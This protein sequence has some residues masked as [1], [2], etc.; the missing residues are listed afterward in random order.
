MNFPIPTLAFSS[1]TLILSGLSERAV[2]RIFDAE[3][4]VADERAGYW[5]CDASRYPQVRA[6]L[7]KLIGTVDDRVPQW[8]PVNWPKTVLHPLRA[9][10]EQAVAAWFQNSGRGVVLMPTGTGKTEVAL[11]ILARTRTSTLVIAPVRDLMYQWHRRLL[12]K[13]GV[14]AGIIGDSVYRVSPVSVT[15]YDSACIHMPRFGNQFDVLVFDE[16]H[17]LPGPVRRDAALMSA[18]RYRLGLTATLERSDGAHRDLGDLIGPLAYELTVPAARGKSLADYNVIRI[19]VH[20]TESERIR[21]ESL[22]RQ[23]TSFVQ[24]RRREDPHFRW[25]D[26]CAQAN[27]DP[28]AR[29]ALRAFHTKKSMED[30]AEEKLRVLED[31]F[32][33][34]AG[35]PV[36]VFTGSNA[37]ARDVS[38]RFLIPCLLNHCGKRERL[39]VLRGLENGDYPALVANRVLDEG[40]DLPE[41]KVAV[42]IGGSGS[43]RQAKQRLGR[44]LRRRGNQRAVLYEIVTQDTAEVKRSRRRRKSDAYE[45]TRHLRY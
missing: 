4:W 11:T 33:L 1:G 6:G 10:Q 41:V 25:E 42:V 45:G 8:Q 24:E 3:L 37:M 23:I 36:I 18:A 28:A 7:D 15:T 2:Q 38:L 21:Y 26:A 29:K 39:D 16:C 32:R 27:V 22:T 13:L 9:E 35:E 14:D 17:H 31:L 12:E 40:V 30:R 43:G 34:H 5:R 44:I 19:P 20:L